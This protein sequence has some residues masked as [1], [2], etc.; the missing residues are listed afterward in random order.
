MTPTDRLIATGRRNAGAPALL[1]KQRGLSDRFIAHMLA[2]NIRVEADLLEDEAHER[3]KEDEEHGDH[4]PARIVASAQALFT[5]YDRVA[6]LGHAESGKT[7]IALTRPMIYH[8]RISSR[9]CR[10]RTK[11]RLMS[12]GPRS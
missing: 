1:H 2:R 3:R 10:A 7:S 8:P 4:L 5:E 11:A 9:S 6:L 12:V